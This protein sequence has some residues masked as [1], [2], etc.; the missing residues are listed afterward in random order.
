MRGDTC[1]WKLLPLEDLREMSNHQW[2]EPTDVDQDWLVTVFGTLAGQVEEAASAS[3]SK[4]AKGIGSLSE[5][6]KPDPEEEHLEAPLVHPYEHRK[7]AGEEAENFPDGLFNADS[8]PELAGDAEPVHEAEDEELQTVPIHEEIIK[9]TY[10]F[11]RVYRKVPHL[12]VA[13][14]KD[15]KRLLLGLRE[16]MWHCPITDF[17]SILSRMDTHLKFFV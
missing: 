14:E 7:E 3:S 13:N 11:R 5:R 4:S 6:K 1:N 8:A 12:A 9:P 16:R 15:A 10:D 17:R 2:H